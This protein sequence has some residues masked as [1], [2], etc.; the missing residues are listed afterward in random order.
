MKIDSAKDKILKEKLS[1]YV[2]LMQGNIKSGL[3]QFL[4]EDSLVVDDSAL[5]EYV[6]EPQKEKSRH[7][8][9]KWI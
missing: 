4:D 3:T 7:K 1:S 2:T 8:S 9:Q 6:F 5:E